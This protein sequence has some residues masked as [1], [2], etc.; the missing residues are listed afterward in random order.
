MLV[1]LSWRKTQW[2]AYCDACLVGSSVVV[3]DDPRTARGWAV[4]KLR[5][6]GW[7]HEAP[8]DLPPAGQRIAESAWTGETFCFECSSS[9]VR[10]RAG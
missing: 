5:A 7:T 4:A 9:R 6:L 10:M 8:P 2:A 3:W 1:T